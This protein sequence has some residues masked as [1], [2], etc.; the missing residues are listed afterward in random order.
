MKPQYYL[1]GVVSLTLAVMTQGQPC[2]PGWSDQFSSSDLDLWVMDLAVFDDGGGPA[3]YASGAF[4]NAGSTKVNHVAKL[5]GNN[6]KPLAGGIGSAV[7]AL[8]VCQ[9]CP[10]AGA[11]LYAGGYFQSAGAVEAHGVA[12]WDG[13]AWSPLGQGITGN[14]LGMV[15]SLLVV[16]P[17][18]GGGP[19]LYAAG[20]FD[21]AGGVPAQSIA[22]W[23]GA[24]WSALGSGLDGTVWALAFFDDGSGPA[25]Y[26]G[27]TFTMAGNV[28]VNH[29]AR[30][31]GLSWSPVGG[32]A[33]DT[34][35]AMAVFDDGSGA[36]LFAA[37]DFV[38]AGGAAIEKIARW[39]GVAWTS[40]RGGGFVGYTPYV[41]E[42]SIFDDGSGPALVAGGSFFGVGGIEAANIAK[43]DGSG[44]HALGTGTEHSVWAM[45]SI[46][47][48]GGSG[49]SLYVGGLFQGAGLSTAQ[50]IAMWDGSGWAQIGPG[51]DEV[52]YGMLAVDEKAGPAPGL[53]VA[54]DFASVGGAPAPGIAHWDGN[55]WSDLDGGI[56]GTVQALEVFDGGQGPG[57]YAGGYF[58]SAGGIQAYSIARWDGEFWSRLGDGIDP[59][60]SAVRALQVFDAPDEDEPKLYVG[61][62][63]HRAGDQAASNIAAWDGET[64][65]ALGSGVASEPGSIAYVIDLAVFDDGSGPALYVGGIFDSAGG[66][67]AHSIARWDGAAWSSVGAG[68]ESGVVYALAVFDDGSGPALY[69]GGRFSLR[70]GESDIVVR[71]DG[72][73]WLGVGSSSTDFSYALALGVYDD[74]TSGGPALYAAGRFAEVGGVAANN[75]ASWNGTAWSALGAGIIVEFDYGYVWDL[76]TYDEGSGEGATLFAGGNFHTAGQYSADNIAGWGGCTAAVFGDITADGA[77]NQADLTA[78]LNA[79]GPCPG[80]CEPACPAD[81][82]GNCTVDVRDMLLLIAHWT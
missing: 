58:Q 24:S 5:E 47:N 66:V 82:D 80:S 25:L 69:A 74:G 78:L 61:G 56:D 19:R 72:S 52:I 13:Q 37:G 71:W 35:W 15:N 20:F 40:L 34:V 60:D 44:W 18:P 79:W 12:R 8:A 16:E 62:V 6:W 23:D 46:D 2:Q 36:A 68:L 32:G 29:I 10:G 55:Q 57:L 28:E 64:W 43:W 48:Q 31:D 41:H 1:S 27:G 22:Q 7:S 39:D 53:Y 11:S 77:V 51:S 49:Q 81:L 45:A 14:P 17:G 63:F 50:H 33:D 42:L 67:A 59:S 4:S 65:S 38:A 21:H 26:A 73:A 70:K 3:V 75:I 30:W 54:G 76:A 9:E